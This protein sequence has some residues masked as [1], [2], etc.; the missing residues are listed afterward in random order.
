MKYKN[1]SVYDDKD[2]FEKYNQ[3]RSKGKY[4]HK[5]FNHKVRLT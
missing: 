3:K 4:L 2:F 5:L 1:Y